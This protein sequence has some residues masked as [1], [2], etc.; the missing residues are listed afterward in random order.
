MDES[1]AHRHF[2]TYCFNSTWDLIDQTDRSETE[3]AQMLLR[4]AASL[5]HWSERDDCTPQNLSVGYWQLSR[6]LALLGEA[7]LAARIGRIC[8]DV[9]P[10]DD[11]F[12]VG[13]AYEALARA[14]LVAGDKIEMDRCLTE[15]TLRA[16]QVK[17]ADKRESLEA[18]LA[19]IAPMP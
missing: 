2:A 3:S 16:G 4:S 8:L 1:T 18:D 9:S 10:A 12:L 11:P 17:D 14:A 5:W 6:V 13:F 19:T 7:S 15:A